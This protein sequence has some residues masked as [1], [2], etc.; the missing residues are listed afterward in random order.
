[1]KKVASLL[2]FILY[3]TTMFGQTILLYNLNKGRFYHKKVVGVIKEGLL[4]KISAILQI[5]NQNIPAT[6]KS[7]ITYELIN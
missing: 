1:M 3:G 4:E 2:V 5:G 6:I 7:K